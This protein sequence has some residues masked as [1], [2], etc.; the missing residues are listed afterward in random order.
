MVERLLEK[1]LYGQPCNGCG[2]CCLALQC[3]VSIEVFGDVG[4]EGFCPALT[5][6]GGGRLACGLMSTPAEFLEMP[7]EHAA[8]WSRFFRLMIGAGTWCDSEDPAVDDP[9]LAAHEEMMQVEANR[10][11]I[12]AVKAELAT[13]KPWE[14]RW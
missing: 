4:A 11:R 7:V 14:Q 9:S 10:D 13:L 3:A 8:Q 6:V 2:R 1:P 12:A 5:P